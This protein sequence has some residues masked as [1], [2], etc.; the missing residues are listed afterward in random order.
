M[1]H[2]DV[3]GCVLTFRVAIEEWVNMLPCA[4]LAHPGVSSYFALSLGRVGA[5]DVAKGG[6][7]R[8]LWIP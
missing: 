1:M 3:D 6:P 8:A 2:V 5:L 4:H 7:S